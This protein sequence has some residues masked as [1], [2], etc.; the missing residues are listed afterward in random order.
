[1]WRWTRERWACTAYTAWN[2]LRS[3]TAW[4]SPRVTDEARNNAALARFDPD[5]RGALSP[6]R[7]ARGWIGRSRG[8]AVWHPLSY[9]AA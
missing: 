9:L 6:P 5:I 4:G 2:N 7:I 8:W 3:L 1:M